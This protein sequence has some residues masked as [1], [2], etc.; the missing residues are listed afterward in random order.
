MA[1][2]RPPTRSAAGLVVGVVVLDG[3]VV[4]LDGTGVDA[5]VLVVVVARTTAA[6]GVL[7]ALTRGPRVPGLDGW[8][9]TTG[10]ENTPSSEHAVSVSPREASETSVTSAAMRPR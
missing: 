4:V 9:G 1:V 7:P 6:G 5:G 8:A 2:T 10:P 3:S